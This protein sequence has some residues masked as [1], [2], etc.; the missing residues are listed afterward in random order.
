[1][2]DLKRYW[3]ALA[4]EPRDAARKAIRYNAILSIV[5]MAILI[6][7]LMAAN[8]AVAAENVPAMFQVL[9]ALVLLLVVTLGFTIYGSVLV[10]RAHR[11][12]KDWLFSLEAPGLPTRDTRSASDGLLLATAL[13]AFASLPGNLLGLV[14]S[15]LLDTWASVP[16]EVIWVALGLIL[17]PIA[18]RRFIPLP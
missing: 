17:V 15:P 14:L 7:A 9:G 4:A 3:H 10:S 2:R 16:V 18:A 11:A 6:A 1:M 8:G 12:V 13:L 5:V